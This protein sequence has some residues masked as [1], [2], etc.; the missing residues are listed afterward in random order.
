VSIQ[1]VP[2]PRFSLDESSGITHVVISQ[3]RRWFPLLFITCWLGGW[4]AGEIGAIRS[5][6]GP[7]DKSPGL[8]LV[9]W[10]GAWTVGGCWA[11]W[12]WLQLLRGTEEMRVDG[13]VLAVESGYNPLRPTKE[14]AL[15]EV[16]NLRV[17]TTHTGW[18]G[19]SGRDFWGGAP[20]L[21]FD[22]GG[23]TICFGRGMS[24]AEAA[25]LIAE[26]RKRHPQLTLP[27]H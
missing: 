18:Y 23:D 2:P 15:N 14:Y 8:F 25:Q 22:Y 1:A 11:I 21:K 3:R 13:T 20:A 19:N 7:S 12:T 9:F 17:I 10:L 26:L 27:A 16:R 5:L 6:L 24:E 4:A